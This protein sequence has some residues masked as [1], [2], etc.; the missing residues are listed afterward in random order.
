MISARIKAKYEDHNHVKAVIKSVGAIQKGLDYQ[1]DT[2]FD[3]P[4]GTL[5]LR[6]GNL[7]NFL[8]FTAPR[9]KE[10]ENVLVHTLLPNSSLKQIL[11]NVFKPLIVVYKSR[12]VFNL[13]KVRFNLDDVK[14][15]GKFIGIDIRDKPDGMS[16]LDML[17]R[18][19]YYTDLLGVDMQ[20]CITCSYGSLLLQKVRA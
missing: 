5:K 1:I 18:L 17:E 15:L 12:E 13:D 9:D 19:N 7:E 8:I 11:M 6:E 3:V 14:D 4:S 16:Y 10:K 2:Y 20:N